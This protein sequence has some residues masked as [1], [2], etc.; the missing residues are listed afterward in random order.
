MENGKMF[1]KAWR[2]GLVVL[3]GLGVFAGCADWQDGYGL[4]VPFAVGDSDGLEESSAVEDGDGLEGSPATGDGMT[5]PGMGTEDGQAENP[6]QG[7]GG[8]LPGEAA[9]FDSG[10]FSGKIK[11]LKYAG[12]GKLLVYADALSLYDV[13][14]DQVL[15]EFQF[16]E[17]QVS[18]DGFYPLPEGYALFG[19]VL[20]ERGGSQDS[21]GSLNF[22]EVTD[23]EEGIRCWMFDENLN[24]QESLDLHRMLKE[25]GE[26]EVEFSAAASK[27][28][29]QIVIAGME[30]LY[31][32]QVE[33]NV[34]HVL[35]DEA[36]GTKSGALEHIRIMNVRFASDLSSN[37]QEHLIFTG[38]AIPEGKSNS[39]PIYGTMNLDGSGLDCRTASDF[40]LSGDFL[41][42]EK[43][44]WFLEDF[45]DAEGRVLVTD[46]AG[47]SLRILELEGE[48]AGEDG[49]FGSDQG[50]YLAT[51]AIPNLTADWNGGWR[52]RIYDSQS[53]KIIWEQ[54]VGMDT[55]A[56]TG[57]GCSVKILDGTRECIVTCGREGKTYTEAYF[58]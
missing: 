17:G 51:L 44:V 8:F 25:E 35:L 30:K 42:Y 16:S 14:S 4:G 21:S 36:L 33:E 10:R 7:A 22:T 29:T 23:H 43:E 53:G 18:L 52:L 15:G 37:G 45:Q 54:D 24:L 55:E 19:E 48:D 58:F 56:Y 28:G 34:F 46:P 39:I 9:L 20:P 40:P 47:K 11:S 50:G 1:Q 27:D 32:Y 6:V 31:L 26:D 2:L 5:A 13:A 3:C 57:V 41:V 12:G 38:I 49:V